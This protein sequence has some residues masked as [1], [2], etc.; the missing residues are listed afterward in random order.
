MIKQNMLQFQSKSL[1]TM[2]SCFQVSLEICDALFATKMDI[3]HEC[4]NKVKIKL[5][6]SSKARNNFRARI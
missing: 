2:A 3:N 5:E 6:S 1:A 4:K